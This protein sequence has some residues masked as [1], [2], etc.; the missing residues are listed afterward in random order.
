[1]LPI[2]MRMATPIVSIKRSGSNQEVVVAAR[3]S[4]IITIEKIRTRPISLA[5]FS[6]SIL[7][8]SAGPEYAPRSPTSARIS[9]MAA[10][11]RREESPSTN[12]ISITAYPSL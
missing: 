10:S 8:S 3:I 7:L 4:K 6:L 2:L 9:S 11:V 12:W 5:R 1:M